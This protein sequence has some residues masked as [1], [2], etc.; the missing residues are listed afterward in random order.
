MTAPCACS[1]LWHRINPKTRTPTNSAWL[2]VALSAI[3]GLL[4]TFVFWLY[5]QLSGRKWFTGPKVQGTPEE[6][7]AIEQELDAVER[8]PI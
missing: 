8:G 3:V 4:A 2:G 1:R 5:W 6:L 7:R